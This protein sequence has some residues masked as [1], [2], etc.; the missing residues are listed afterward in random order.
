MTD[1]KST[2]TAKDLNQLAEYAG[3]MLLPAELEQLCCAYPAL[4]RMKTLVRRPRS[5]N[6][7]GADVFELVKQWEV[8]D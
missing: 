1:Q 3:L 2:I 4:E 5:Y 7:E 8:S 6:S